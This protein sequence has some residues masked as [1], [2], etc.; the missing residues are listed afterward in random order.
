MFSLK[1]QQ[2][3]KKRSI[4]LDFKIIFLIYFIENIFTVPQNPLDRGL[5]VHSSC[6]TRLL[7]PTLRMRPAFGMRCRPSLS[8]WETT[9]KTIATTSTRPSFSRCRRKFRKSC[10]S[11][12]DLVLLLLHTTRIARCGAWAG[13]TL[14]LFYK[15]QVFSTQAGC[16]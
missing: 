12:F 2:A 15:N 13:I 16:S 4:D 14:F 8:R 11:R 7:V 6:A 10:C 5:I 1:P 3:C 9:T